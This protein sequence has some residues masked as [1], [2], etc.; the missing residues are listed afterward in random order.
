M[1]LEF[2]NSVGDETLR[3]FCE[4]SN[5]N[6]EW[7]S[8]HGVPFSAEAYVEKT[9]MPPEGKF[10]YYSGNEKVPTY[11]TAAKPAPRGHRTVGK[12]I[13]TGHVLFAALRESARRLGVRFKFH[14]PVTRLIVNK[15]GHVVGV[16][17]GE[18]P[19]T[20]TSQHQALSKRV[21]PTA[22][23]SNSR[24]E[25]AIERCLK[26]E[27]RYL[28]RRLIRARLGIVLST[29]GFEYN[30][31]ML[32][33]YLPRS[34][35]HYR[36]LMRS[37][38]MGSYGSGIRLGLSVGAAMRLMNSKLTSSFVAPPDLLL[39]GIVVNDQG[40][41]FINEDTYAGFLG[42]AIDEQ[43]DSKAWLILDAPTF[44]KVVREIL[45]PRGDG[46]FIPFKLPQLLNIAF[47]GTKRGSSA[48]E[49]AKKCSIDATGL[50]RQIREY[51]QAASSGTPDPLGKNAKYVRPLKERRLYA[52]NKANS[53]VYCFGFF[54]TLGGLDV[55]EETGAVKL[56]GGSIIEGL[57][58]AGRTAV[59]ICS[60]TY[61]SGLSLADVVFSGRRAARSLMAQSR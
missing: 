36:A 15:A 33:R 13:W 6:L 50:T 45:T 60:Q 2:G 24:A 17:I 30:V 32:Q 27:A 21:S 55:N 3:R 58:A 56:P 39:Q 42:N 57:Y 10:L 26:L 47:G 12:G 4:E 7:L 19:A 9:A 41:R 43:A 38:A 35:S 29:G 31:P 11:A 37:G 48:A 44:W 51:N 61:L 16:E 1:H 59:G 14:S 54:M 22:P 8:A 18:L 46:Q 5:A 23:F 53:N 52:I 40:Q 28:Q 25:T 34:A 49:I 20:L